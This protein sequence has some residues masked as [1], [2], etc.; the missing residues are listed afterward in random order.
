[1]HSFIHIHRRSQTRRGAAVVEFAITVPV[2][3][4]LLFAG[5]EASA[6]YM[7]YNSLEN[8]SYEG[9]R[10][11]IIPGASSAAIR[12][13]CLSMLSAARVTSPLVSVSPETITDDT[14]QVIVTTSASASGNLF[15]INWLFGDRIISR[16][17]TMT[18][19]GYLASQSPSDP[20]EPTSKQRR[21]GRRRT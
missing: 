19:E 16:T 13:E 12:S 1:M 5:M 18:R 11:G 7:M 15:G 17:T 4:L 6:T 3:L 10:R 14:Q 9:A 20:V 2:A 21:G 8:A